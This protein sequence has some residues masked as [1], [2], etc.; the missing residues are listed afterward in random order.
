MFDGDAFNHAL[1]FP[2]REVSAPPRGAVDTMIDVGGVR[3]HTRRHGTDPC[4]LLLFH[5]NG[6][7]VADYD[8]MASQFTDCGVSLV[9]ADYRGYGA[10]EGEPTLRHV[11]ADARAIAEAVRPQFVMGRSLGG[12]AAHELYVRPIGGMI[13]VILE[14]TFCDLAGLIRRRGL[15]PPS[16]FS[17]EERATFDPLAKLPDGRL[18]LLILHGERDQLIGPSEA[19][20]ALSVA[21]SADK[22]LVLIP[23]H[24]HNDVSVSDTYWRALVAF[25]ARVTSTARTRT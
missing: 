19:R 9:V 25:I 16:A 3:V 6:E 12:A 22:E 13:G 10:S 11:I 23:G 24:G 2:R 7:I 8:A 18:P 15:A 20:T 5:G 1:F 14:S 21:G 4:T 17:A